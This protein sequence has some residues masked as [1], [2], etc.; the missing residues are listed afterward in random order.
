MHVYSCKLRISNCSSAC[1]HFIRRQVR[2]RSTIT[3]PCCQCRYQ[4]LFK[5]II[6]L[7]L[8]P[9]LPYRTSEGERVQGP[10]IFSVYSSFNQ[11]SEHLYMDL[12][13]KVA[14]VTG[15]SRG[16][17]LAIVKSLIQANA[18]VAFTFAS[19]SS[20]E[21][22]EKLVQEIGNDKLAGYKCDA[23]D[24][25]LQERVH[26]I[27]QAVE[28]KFGRVTIL[29]NNAGILKRGNVLEVTEQDLDN[30]MNVNIKS[31]ILTT[32]TFAKRFVQDS[33]YGR[34][35]N[36]GSNL[37]TRSGASGAGIYNMTKAA[38]A[39]LTKTWAWDLASL[40][41]TVN[42]VEPGSTDTD[43]NPASSERAKERRKTIARG[44]YGKPEDIAN[45]VIFFCLHSSRHITGTCLRVDGGQEA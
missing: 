14:L 37:A 8:F 18:K 3:P 24:Q 39:S 19:K 17:G 16:I 5:K 11:N 42:C 6:A 35:V 2:Q 28:Q 12:T 45:A 40:N 32:Q 7:V 25:R 34:V 22:S 21:A 23:S 29:V 10:Y 31:V 38:V 36:I 33:E 27:L 13:G 9:K 20:E 43:M 41:I 44:Q 1:Q 4:K 30:L 26:E 15:G